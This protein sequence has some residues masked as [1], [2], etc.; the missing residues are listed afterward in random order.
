MNNSQALTKTL[1]ELGVKYIFGLPGEENL[2]VLEALSKSNIKFITTRHEQSAGFMAATVGRLTGEPGVC[3]ST[4]G[5]GASNL[6]TPLAYSLLCGFPMIAI[7]GQKPIKNNE[8]ANFQWVDIVEMMKSVTKHSYQLNK[9]DSINRVF[10]Q[11][12]IK[13]KSIKSGPTLVELPEDVI[14]ADCQF[15]VKSEVVKPEPKSADK[16]NITESLKLLKE[17]KAIVIVLGSLINDEETADYIEHII[18]KHNI[19]FLYSQMG[20]GI[21]DESHPLCLGTAALSKGDYLHESF[22]AADLIIS[23]GYDLAEKPPFVL[24]EGSNKK[25]I[26]ISSVKQGEDQYYKPSVSVIGSIKTNLREIFDSEETKDLK[27]SSPFK[28][29]KEKIDKEIRNSNVSDL[30]QESPQYI[31]SEIQKGTN[32][33]ASI[34]LDNGLYKVWFARNFI[35]SHRHN[36]LLDNNL[37]TMGAG[38]P[39]AIATKIVFPER[40]VLALCGDGGFMMNSQALEVAVRLNLDLTVIVL[41]DEAYG[42]IK[43][44]QENMGFNDFALDFKNPDFKLY[45]ESYGVKH[46]LV[47]SENS[48]SSILKKTNEDGGVNLVSCPVKYD[49]SSLTIPDNLIDKMI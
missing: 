8:Q 3:L 4:L 17:S 18:D 2:D 25:I 11:M 28:K 37:A 29:T 9:T 49:A 15:D 12:F 43:W 1:Q 48:L 45:A 32:K 44:K 38:L 46:W 14:Q 7:T 35:S 41:I 20:K 21:I 6:S 42:M 13:S 10:K 39:S 36:L 16:K 19:Y 31:I 23:I 24:A 33:E 47:G 34:C 40:Q 5:P 26:H 30:P 22:D 27:N